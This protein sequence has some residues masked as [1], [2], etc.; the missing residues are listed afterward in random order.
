ME[1]L[2]VSENLSFQLDKYQFIIFAINHLPAKLVNGLCA[3]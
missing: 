2:N 3:Y 1:L